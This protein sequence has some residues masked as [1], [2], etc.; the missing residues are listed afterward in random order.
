MTPLEL[1]G[2]ILIV[3][4][5]VLSVL[6]AWGVLDFPSALARMHAATK[7]A[8]LGLTLIALGAAIAAESWGLLGI[9]V[10][11]AAFLFLT[12]PISGHMVGRATYLAGR[13]DNLVHDD[14]ATATP[15][16]TNVRTGNRSRFSVGRV[17]GVAIVWM[18]L[19]RNVSLGTLLGGIAA[20]IGIEAIRK[21]PAGGPG[22][23]P[24]GL[25]VFGLRYAW[26]VCV[27]NA[28]VAWEVITPSNEQIREA[29]V[30][31]PLATSTPEVGLLV[32]NAISFT[33]GSL[34]IEMTDDPLVLYVHVLHFES[35]T[36][37]EQDVHELEAF[38]RKVFRETDN[39]QPV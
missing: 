36:Q 5:T 38:A 2:G 10:L 25:L 6:A 17:V 15:S 33:P 3:A 22:I 29:I 20:G 4:G 1:L 19:W 12:A 30:A 9:A 28:R 13:V 37:V 31:V 14:L 34:T 24:S 8:S 18:L 23:R 32:A 39:V 27:S 21:A 7:S 35:V 16:P 26:M 11:V